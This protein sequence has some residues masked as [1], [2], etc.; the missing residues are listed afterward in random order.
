MQDSIFPLDISLTHA[1]CYANN[2]QSLEKLV[3]LSKNYNTPLY[4][5][6]DIFGV[7]A[8][9]IA[10]SQTNT[11]LI[12]L[13]VNALIYSPPPLQGISSNFIDNIQK[14]LEMRISHLG[15]LIDSRLIEAQG[16][17]P[18]L[19]VYSNNPKNKAFNSLDISHI[20]YEE[21]LEINPKG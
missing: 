21:M 19:G 5:T 15:D 3:L 1:F 16:E 9:D 14:L 11:T 18:S 2:S 4:L 12:N 8:L 7:T 6:K 10:I 20:E 13:I 17:K